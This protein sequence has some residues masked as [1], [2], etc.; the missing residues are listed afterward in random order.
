MVEQDNLVEQ[1]DPAVEREGL[2]GTPAQDSRPGQLV[3]GVDELVEQDDPV[4][5]IG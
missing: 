1:N 5:T 4:G 3:P 2:A